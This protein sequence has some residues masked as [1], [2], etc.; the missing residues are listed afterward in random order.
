MATAALYLFGGGALQSFAL[1]M[2]F[3]IVVATF[4]SIYI[5]APV[6]IAFRLRSLRPLRGKAA[7]RD[8]ATRTPA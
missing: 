4:S 2:F 1:V 6:L 3:G 8:A 5:A 7:R